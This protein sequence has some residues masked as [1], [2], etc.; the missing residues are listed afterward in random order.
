MTGNPLKVT[1]PTFNELATVLARGGF[2]DM[3]QEDGH[4]HCGDLLITADDAAPPF[5]RAARTA[6]V[7]D[8]LALRDNNCAPAWKCGDTEISVHPTSTGCVILR[9]DSGHE[10]R[11][12]ELP[13]ECLSIV[14]EGVIDAMAATPIDATR[15]S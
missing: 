4:I 1:R 3:L 8:D 9:R 13:R 5:A 11:S 14:V 15:R 2:S 7:I 10:G 12:V 6:Q